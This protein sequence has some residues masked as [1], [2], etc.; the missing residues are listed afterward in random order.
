[1]V[2]QETHKLLVGS[3]N[4]PLGTTVSPSRPRTDVAKLEIPKIDHYEIRS[5]SASLEKR[6]KVR[7]AIVYRANSP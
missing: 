5:V 1:M 4:L 7:R 6:S 2:E 3:S